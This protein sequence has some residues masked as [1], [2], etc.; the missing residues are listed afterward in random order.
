MK[1]N[2]KI[3][4]KKKELLVSFVQKEIKRIN[5]TRSRDKIILR[6]KKP[7]PR[8]T[9][10][11]DSK[12]GKLQLRYLIQKITSD[13]IHGFK[14]VHKAKYLRDVDINNY[15][16][17]LDVFA[18][19]QFVVEQQSEA[20]EELYVDEDS[21]VTWV[22]RFVDIEYRKK[23]VILE[24][25]VISERTISGY[26]SNLNNYVSFIKDTDSKFLKISNHNSQ[27]GVEFYY[28]YLRH[29]GEKGGLRNRPWGS[30]TIHSN[31][32]CVRTFWNWL[33]R[34]EEMR[35][36][37]NSRYSKLEKIPS[38]DPKRSS[39]DTMEIRKVIEFMDEYKEHNN[40]FWFVK[41]LR[42]MLVS[43]CRISEVT[44]MKINELQS[45]TATGDDGKPY[46][47]WRWNF[48]GKGDKVRTIFIDSSLAYKDIESLILDSNG[49][50]RTDKEYVFHRHFFKNSNPN[51]KS[52]GAGWIERKELHYSLS[53]IQHKFKKM[54][55]FLGLNKDLTPHSCRRFFIQQKLRETN[56]DLNLVR[57]LVGHSS[58]KMVM[59]YHNTDTEYNSLIGVR[60][61]LNLGEVQKRNEKLGI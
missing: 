43:G 54:V 24:K 53:G 26:R 58:L 49:K 25:D 45:L 9:Y 21:M 33:S 44:T 32:R 46:K 35:W 56:G 10:T 42:V 15:K 19:Y 1:E 11:I 16:E 61:T 41:I 31:Y 40:W 12:S 28:S 34:R 8:F 59:H 57:L 55:K 47:V 4:A 18:N 60:N 48:K 14:K 50:I 22:D 17:R 20:I 23:D 36:F 7:D 29:K 27:E 39:F 13:S 52:M 51:Q 37:D 2:L 5:R 6:G 30:T 38:P 3:T